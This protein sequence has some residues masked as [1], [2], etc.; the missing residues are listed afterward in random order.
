MSLAVNAAKFLTTKNHKVRVVSMPCSNVFDKQTSEYK[1][2]LLPNTVP[3]I[4]IEA[5]VTDFW[6]K[7]AGGED[8]L[9]LGVDSFGESGPGKDLFEHFKIT[10][11]ESN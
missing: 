4:A 3:K 10:E 7:Y 5:G 1:M 9:V 8:D 11:E 6:Y 2:N